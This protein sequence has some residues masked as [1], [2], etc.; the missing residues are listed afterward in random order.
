MTGNRV[1]LSITTH[2]CDNLSMNNPNIYS[3]PPNSGGAFF[4]GNV[5][6]A[7]SNSIPFNFLV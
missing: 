6:N 1:N 5:L 4:T 2:L 3:G 7:L